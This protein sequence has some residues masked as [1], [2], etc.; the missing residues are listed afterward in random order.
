MLSGIQPTATSFHLGNYLGALKQWVTLQ[1]GHDAFYCVVDLHAIT[2]NPPTP[3]ELGERTRVSVAQ[4]IAAGVDPDRCTVFL[5]SHVPEHTQLAWVLACLTGQG[6]A[7][8]MTQFKDKSARNP[9]RVTVG[10]YTYPILMAADIL[11]YHAD[12]VPVGED[13]RQHL[14]LTRDLAQ[15]FNTRYG[16]TFTVPQPYIP[17]Q[18]AKI[19]DLQRPD[20]EDEQ[21]TARGRHA[22]V[23]RRPGGAGAQGEAGGHGR[24]LGGHL[25]S[26][27]QARCDE[28]ADRAGGGDRPG[29][30]RRGGRAGGQRLRAR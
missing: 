13:Q 3:A 1:D 5:Q 8:R 14:E 9:N 25:G 15:R 20:R 6:E 23:A 22:V 12:L 28:P 26:G 11:L 29:G 10:L 7:A 27:R 17:R 4:L 24:R 21:V 2:L 18:T 30:R 19:F 16:A